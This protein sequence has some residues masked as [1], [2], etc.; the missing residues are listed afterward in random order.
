VEEFVADLDYRILFVEWTAAFFTVVGRVPPA[1]K[2]D[3]P[4]LGLGVSELGTHLTIHY[5]FTHPQFVQI[6][7]STI[8]YKHEGQ[9]TEAAVGLSSP[10]AASPSA[11]PGGLFALVRL[12]FE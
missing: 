11:F 3:A 9:V 12:K 5:G 4:G 6:V 1:V 7:P 2:A 8:S 10:T